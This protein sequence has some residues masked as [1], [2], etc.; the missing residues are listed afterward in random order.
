LKA[1]SAI[2]V[3]RVYSSLFT[4]RRSGTFQMDLPRRKRR[5]SCETI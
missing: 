1:L 3:F 2:T 5:L 4:L